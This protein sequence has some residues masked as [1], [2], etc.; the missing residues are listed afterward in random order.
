M[1]SSGDRASCAFRNNK[2]TITS[3]VLKIG[4]KEIPMREGR[5][6]AFIDK[7]GAVEKIVALDPAKKREEA[8]LPAK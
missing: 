8:A 4:E 3:G 5:R 6:V 7:S 1:T 2:F